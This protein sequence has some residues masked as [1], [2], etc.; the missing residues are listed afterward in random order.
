A[1]VFRRR[2][3]AGE[4][5]HP[6]QWLLYGDWFARVLLEELEAGVAKQVLDVAAPAGDE[7]IDA[8]DPVA[9]LDQ[10]IAQVT[11]DKTRSPREQHGAR[12]VLPQTSCSSDFHRQVTPP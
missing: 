5:H 8:N 7:I 3:G 6:V 1:Q 10:A 9:I 2:G 4:V 12:A 11:A